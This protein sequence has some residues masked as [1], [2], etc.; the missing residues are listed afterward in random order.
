MHKMILV[1]LYCYAHLDKSSYLDN[2]AISFNK[3]MLT[4]HSTDYI[5]NTLTSES[6][7]VCIKKR[8]GEGACLAQCLL[9]ALRIVRLWADDTDPGHCTIGTQADTNRIFTRGLFCIS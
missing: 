6:S 2:W 5:M 3:H 1:T 7:D 9:S 4:Q 8:G